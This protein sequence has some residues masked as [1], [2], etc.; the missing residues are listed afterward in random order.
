MNTIDRLQRKKIHI[1]SYGCTYNHAD[2]ERLIRI[3]TNQDCVLVPP[4][5]A[6]VA[7]INT[8][9]V[10]G[11]TERR[12]IRRMMHFREKEVVVT[13]CMPLVQ[14]DAI[15]RVCTPQVIYP[16]QIAE[17]SPYPGAITH[18]ATGAVQVARGCPGRCSYCITRLARG[19]LKS[20]RQDEVVRTIRALAER[21]AKEIQLTGQD[22][23]AWG[24]DIGQSLPDLMQEISEIPGK[25][26]VRVGMMNPATIAG[27]LD[28]LVDA[29]A[30]EKFFRFIH[31]PVQSGSDTILERMNRG[32][33]AEDFTGIV[34]AFRERYPEIRLSTDFI[35]GFPGEDDEDFQKS[36]GILHRTRPTKVN[37]TRYSERPLT[38]STAWKDIPEHVKKKRS[39]E[40]NQHAD[41]LYDD[42]YNRLIGREIPFVVTEEKVR[43]TVTVRDPSYHNIV[44]RETLPPG[45]EGR[46]VITENRRYYL[47]AE[48]TECRPSGF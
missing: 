15:N 28:D 2:G 31:I 25:F 32:Y 46:A 16:D 42:A 18:D 35:V 21:G 40:L 7:I 9:T 19:P 1:E 45:S 37:I 43:G 13:G 44:I 3:L 17:R 14:M 6:E 34:D 41:R 23:S 38:E 33:S 12:M 27:I 29:F 8:C 20:Y 26:Y 4:E 10:V 11:A 22:V 5:E 24:R 47:I 30:D 36:V 48:R 39:R